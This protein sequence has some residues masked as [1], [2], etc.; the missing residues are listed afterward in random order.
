MPIIDTEGENYTGTELADRLYVLANLA[1]VSGAGGDDRITA[2]LAAPDGDLETTLSG[3]GGA[4]QISVAMALDDFATQASLASL[5]YGGSEDDDISVTYDVGE[6]E[7]D[8]TS[9]VLSTTVDGGTGHDSIEIGAQGYEISSN[10][11]YVDS[12]AG[13]DVVSV[14]FAELGY[15]ESGES[16]TTIDAGAGADQVAASVYSSTGSVEILI[17]GGDGDDTILGIAEAVSDY[18]K[19]A[20]NEARGG[21][22]NDVIELTSSSYAGAAVS[23]AFGDGGD[24][25]ITTRVGSYA[26]G[27]LRAELYGGEGADRLKVSGGADNFL[28]GNQGNDTLLGSTGDDRMIGGQ[29]NDYLRGYAGDDTFEFQSARDGERDR[30]E[31]FVIG[32]DVIDVS[33]IDANVFRGG[34]QAFSFDATGDGGTG[35]LWLE[36]Y[37]T[38]SVLHADTGRAILDMVLLDGGV[39]ADDYAAS[40]F[41]L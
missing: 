7:A 30:I 16:H 34:N 13:D 25:R 38:K 31:G 12:G 37:G 39:T 40:D 6:H 23:V 9:I 41:I 32:D 10:E 17:D 27:T 11:A 24:D 35:R 4:D 2:A 28:T 3:D 29:G 19:D 20:Y 1:T 21:D 36:D 33:R 14:D 18:N 5:L 22:G 15:S 26:E 8:A